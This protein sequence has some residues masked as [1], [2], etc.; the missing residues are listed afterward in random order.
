MADW[1]FL[2]IVFLLLLILWRTRAV[3]QTSPW[4]R[5]ALLRRIFDQLN[6]IEAAVSQVE[7]SEIEKWAEA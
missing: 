6:Q 7:V 4:L 2:V 5:D 3:G 1:Q